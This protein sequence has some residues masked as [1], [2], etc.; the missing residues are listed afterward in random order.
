MLEDYLD[1]QVTMEHQM[2]LFKLVVPAMV[3]LVIMNLMAQVVKDMVLV[4]ALE[5][6]ALPKALVDIHLL[7]DQEVL[8]VAEKEALVAVMSIKVEV[9]RHMVV[10]MEQPVQLIQVL[11]AEAEV[12][13]VATAV[14][15]P[16][17]L[18]GVP[19]ADQ[20]LS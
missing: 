16:E 6:E 17:H 3:V 14:L 5:Q 1:R 18:V 10:T 20:V 7:Q 13:I 11:V 2:S 4:V 19:L 12:A 9:T 15:V 8:M